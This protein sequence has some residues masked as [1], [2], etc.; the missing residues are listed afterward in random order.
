M[1]T[2]KGP[3]F[4]LILDELEVKSALNYTAK[5]SKMPLPKKKLSIYFFY[6]KKKQSKNSG[7]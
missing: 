1:A 7:K 2:K 3:N 6:Y 4:I 5:Q